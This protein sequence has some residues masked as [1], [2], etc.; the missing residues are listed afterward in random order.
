MHE[1]TMEEEISYYEKDFEKYVFDSWEAFF[2]SEK[3]AYTR[4]S[5]LLE[6]AVKDLGLEKNDKVYLHARGITA[7]SIIKGM[8][9]HET[10]DIYEKMPPNIILLRATFPHNWDE[11]RGKTATIFKEKTGGTVKLI[12]DTTHILHWD[13]PEIVVEE[14][15]R[16]WFK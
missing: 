2:K 15:R 7:S 16:N 3:K 5:P 6:I 10:I 11:Y 8:H 13:K 4:W 9:K 1:E 14:I 12:P